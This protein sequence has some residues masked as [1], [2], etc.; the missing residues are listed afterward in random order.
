[1]F[2]DLGGQDRRDGFFDCR[3]RQRTDSKIGGDPADL[4]ESNG[5]KCHTCCVTQAD[6]PRTMARR[7]ELAVG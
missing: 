2:A 6:A 4:H 3:S 7:T 1:M 5:G